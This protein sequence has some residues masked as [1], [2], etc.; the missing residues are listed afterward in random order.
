MPS[1]KDP[2][3]AFPS[4]TSLKKVTL[5]FGDQGHHSSHPRPIRSLLLKPISVAAVALLSLPTDMR[6]RPLEPS[7]RCRLSPPLLAAPHGFE[8]TSRY[9]L[10]S[11]PA[12]RPC[13][14]GVVPRPESLAR[15]LSETFPSH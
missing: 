1:Y 14:A 9:L 6:I 8:P 4:H 13:L 3:N 5:E 15:Q 11:L 7:R 10:S 2:Q 12:D